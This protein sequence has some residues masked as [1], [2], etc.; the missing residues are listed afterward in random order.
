LGI[1]RG[2]ISW[3]VAHE[4]PLRL[5]SFCSLLSPTAEAYNLR[6]ALK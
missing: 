6:P 4:C 3:P 2:R 1:D 5:F